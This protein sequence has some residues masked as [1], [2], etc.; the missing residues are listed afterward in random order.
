[1][2]KKT[3]YQDFDATAL[4]HFGLDS[5]PKYGVTV[6]FNMEEVLVT[7]DATTYEKIKDILTEA[8]VTSKTLTNYKKAFILPRCNVSN[9]RLK[10][11]LKEH[12]ITVTND[13]ELADLIVGHDDI[14]THKLSNGE[15]IPSTVMMGKLWNYETTSQGSL[16][17]TSSPLNQQIVNYPGE[18]IIT[19]K[20]TD[21]IRYYDL[22]QEDCLYDTWMIT[23]LAI[24]LGH[25][26]DTQAIDVVDVD[27]VLHSSAN[28]CILDEELLEDLITQ[29][30]SYN[31]EDKAMAGVV[32]PTI[33]TSEE[34]HLL[35][36]LA[37]QC[38]NSISNDY[39]RNKDIQYWLKK[40]NLYDL[41]C[42]NAESMIKWLEEK[43]LLNVKSFRYLE[44]IVRKEITI[45]NRELYTF[46]V[47]VKKEYQKYLKNA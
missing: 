46:K 8:T 45:N 4:K 27:T 13:Y 40:S 31:T 35:W 5:D 28:N 32:I 42:M 38:F 39:N 43:E 6:N 37:Q 17:N 19:T 18:V 33:D 25:L 26:V 3:V 34:Y 22:E 10:A 14:T 36:K 1:M 41:Y 7:Q 11:A 29:I 12:K 23:G 2:A 24:N 44:P 21:R 9:D 16:K 30:N 47:A 15:N 20:V